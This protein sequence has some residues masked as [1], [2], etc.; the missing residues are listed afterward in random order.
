MKTLVLSILLI[1]TFQV[2]ASFEDWANKI[3]NKTIGL[4]TS[5]VTLSKLELTPDETFSKLYAGS[6]VAT[7]R[8]YN[9]SDTDTIELIVFKY[10][11]LECDESGN[12][13][14]I[15]REDTKKWY[16]KIPP[17]QAR[18]FEHFVVFEGNRYRQY[19]SAI[20]PYKL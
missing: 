3:I 11:F 2:N 18:Y 7:G 9:N 19:I 20:Y 15:I 1:T 5:I 6:Y 8:A 12:D 17:K 10:E 4:D 16:E 14:T 13:C